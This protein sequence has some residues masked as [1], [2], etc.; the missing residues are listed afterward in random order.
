MYEDAQTQLWSAAALTVT[1]VST[2]A[3]DLGAV[4]T[5][6][7][8]NGVIRDIGT[9]EPLC[10]AISVGVAADFTTGNET[11]EFDLITATANDLTTG[12]LIIYQAAILTPA[13]TAGKLAIL[14]IPPRLF[15]AAAQRFM[16]LKYVGGGTTPTIT[17]TAWITMQSMIDSVYY[18]PS[19]FVVN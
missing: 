12:Q 1:A 3:Y 10:I 4:P 2:N 19:L 16:G 11:Y 7:S 8:A 6:G 5:G 14:P 15:N 9:G 18:Y 13:L 17:V